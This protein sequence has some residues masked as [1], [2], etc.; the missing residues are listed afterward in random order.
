MAGLITL[1]DTDALGADITNN[2]T[3]NI[4][5][6]QITLQL[7]APLITE[8]TVYVSISPGVQDDSRN[9]IKAASAI[10]TT[11]ESPTI[12]ASNFSSSFTTEQGGKS[13]FDLSLSKEPTEDVIVA[14]MSQD[15]SEGKTSISGVT[16]NRQLWDLSLIHI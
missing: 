3:I 5:K 8:Q 15:E 4:H 6:T 7:A 14:I 2:A 12:I 9:V 1:K 10:F 13:T 16:F 11:E